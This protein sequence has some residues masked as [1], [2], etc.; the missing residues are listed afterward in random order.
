LPNVVTDTGIVAK[1]YNSRGL[2]TNNADT[3]PLVRQSD[4][5]LWAALKENTLP[6][7]LSL[8]RS[9]DDGFSWERTWT[10]NFAVPNTRKV[11]FGNL[12]TNG[13][14][15]SLQIFEHLDLIVLWQSY[16]DTSLEIFNVEP[17]SWRISNPTVRLTDAPFAGSVP[18]GADSLSLDAPYNDAYV[19]LVFTTQSK[20]V[21]KQL[22]PGYRHV[23]YESHENNFSATHTIHDPGAIVDIVD[24]GIARDGYGRLCCVWGQETL[25]GDN[26]DMYYSISKDDGETWSTPPVKITKEIGHSAWRD[27]ATARLS[28]RARVMGGRQGFVLGYV[29]QNPDVVAKTFVRSLLTTDGATYTLGVQR[30]IATQATRAAEP[31]TGLSW[32]RPPVARLL[33]LSDLGQLRVGYTV[34]EGNSRT[35]VDSIP[36]RIGQEALYQSAYPSSLISDAGS[37]ATEGSTSVQ[38]PVSFNVLGAPNENVDYYALGVVG[39]LTSRYLAGFRKIGTEYRLQ[40]FDPIP[41]AEMNDRSAYWAPIELTTL[42]VFDPQSYENP[43]FGNRGNDDYTAFIERDVRRLYLPPSLHLSRGFVLNNGNFLK[44]TVWLVS[45]DSS[46]YE[47]TQVIPYFYDGQIAFYAANAYVVGPSHNPFSRRILPSE[48]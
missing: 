14:H 33:D 2:I 41:D 21:V 29:H 43:T 37:Y 36:V 48:M 39:R 10:G 26:H 44:R 28:V 1:N 45:F 40:R 24:I 16:F 34:G 6:N 8:Y 3:K 25:V 22:R 30:E 19:W 38:V 31:V 32:F 7:F 13:P 27:P 4:G 46:E 15:L 35:Q 17:F 11:G 47:L 12:N 42:G 18:T 9:T 5:T 20:L 23:R